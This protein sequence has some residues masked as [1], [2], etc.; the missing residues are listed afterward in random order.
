MLSAVCAENVIRID[1]VKV[2]LNV[3]DD[4]RTV[5]AMN[6]LTVTAPSVMCFAPD[7]ECQPREDDQD[8]RAPPDRHHKPVYD[9]FPACEEPDQMNESD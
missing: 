6:F 4:G 5:T 7:Q 8:R 3:G 1:L 2:S 9:D